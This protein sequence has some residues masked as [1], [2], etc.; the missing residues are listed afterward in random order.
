MICNWFLLYLYVVLISSAL[1]F[2]GFIKIKNPYLQILYEYILFIVSMM[3]IFKM[4]NF[5]ISVIVYSLFV[6]SLFI[7]NILS[8]LYDILIVNIQLIFWICFSLIFYYGFQKIK[9]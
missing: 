2:L 5:E 8:I 7:K 1:L 6:I 3:T 4:I 9:N